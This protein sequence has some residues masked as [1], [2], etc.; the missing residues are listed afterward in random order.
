MH[1]Q[2]LQR[3]EDSPGEAGGVLRASYLMT[4]RRKTWR[5]Y[6]WSF[7]PRRRRRCRSGSYIDQMSSNPT[8][9]IHEDIRFPIKPQ[10]YTFR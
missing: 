1:G 5:F 2:G 4:S 8:L 3:L 6:L 7:G 10:H 9:G